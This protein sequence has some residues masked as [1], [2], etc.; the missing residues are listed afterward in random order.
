MKNLWPRIQ[1]AEYFLTTHS[2]MSSSTKLRLEEDLTDVCLAEDAFDPWTRD[3]LMFVA[4]AWFRELCQVHMVL[5]CSKC[6]WL[7]IGK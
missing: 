2:S 1:R 5:T 6:C 4:C 7:Q 3:S